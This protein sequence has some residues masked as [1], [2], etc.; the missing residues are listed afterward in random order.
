MKTVT[1]RIPPQKSGVLSP[2]CSLRRI[3]DR[4][5]G[6]LLPLFAILLIASAPLAAQDEFEGADTGVYVMP[7]DLDVPIEIAEFGDSTL[8]WMGGGVAYDSTDLE[9]RALPSVSQIDVYF[10]DDRFN[11]DPNGYSRDPSL[12]EEILRAIDEFF[13]SIGVGESPLF[14]FFFKILPWVLLV[15]ALLLVLRALIGQKGGRL[16]RRNLVE[17]RLGIEEEIHDIHALDFPALIA[18]A[19]KAED[20]RSAVRYHYLELLGKL[21]QRERIDWRPEKTNGEYLVELRGTRL[22]DPMRSL[23]H[24][25]DYVWYGEFEIGEREYGDYRRDVERIDAVLAGGVDR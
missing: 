15:G 20:Y 5:A 22:S 9:L 13:D 12:L 21:S 24:F 14:E 17:N 23:T 16:F 4:I 3:T 11:Y 2:V 7:D 8:S 19:L 6:G 1:I 10:E 18:A 25:F